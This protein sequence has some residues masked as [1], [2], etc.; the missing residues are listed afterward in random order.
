[1]NKSKY[2][3]LSYKEK[4]LKIRTFVH[5]QGLIKIIGVF[6]QKIF[7]L[8]NKKD[9]K[10]THRC[11]DIFIYIN[12]GIYSIEKY[13]YICLFHNYRKYVYTNIFKDTGR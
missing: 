6:W 3:F 7:M 4:V 2:N 10:S 12:T 8:Y 13:Y 1:M 5:C 9:S 11:P